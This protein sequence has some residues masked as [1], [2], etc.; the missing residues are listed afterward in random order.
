MLCHSGENVARL[1][2][3]IFVDGFEILHPPAASRIL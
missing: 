1:D 2:Q 3:A